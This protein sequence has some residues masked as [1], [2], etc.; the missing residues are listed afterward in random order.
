MISLCLTSGAI[1]AALVIQ[2]FTLAWMHSVEK[3][4]W[5]EDWR[6]ESRQ[7]QIVEARIKGSGAGMEPPEGAVL[8]DGAW[9]YRPAVA[10]MERLILAHSPYTTGYELC[11]QGDCQPLT[12]FL[13]GIEETG[14]IIL[15]PCPG[16]SG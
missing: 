5:E 1:S 12:H 8:L 11:F 14:T 15:A 13:P 3:V 2:S 4:R 6:I 10:P 16:A 7:L 9:H